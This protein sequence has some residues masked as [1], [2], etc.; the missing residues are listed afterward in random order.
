MHD[1]HKVKYDRRET[2]NLLH[3]LPIPDRP[4]ESIA[5]NFIFYLPT[6]P[7]WNDG[8]W[9]IIDNFGKQ[10]HFIHVQKKIGTYHTVKL[11]M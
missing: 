1:M 4:W 3:P 5:M 6:T 8:I 7:T 2:P 10:V 9:T 11:F